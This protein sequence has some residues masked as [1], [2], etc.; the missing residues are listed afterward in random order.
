MN[1]KIGG[2]VNVKNVKDKKV[3]CLTEDQLR[4]IYK[5]VE[6][7]SIVNVDTIRQEI[8]DDK[9]T[10][11]K[12]DKVNPYQKIVVNNIDKD[13][14]PTLQMEDWSVLGNAVNYVQYGRNPNIFHE[15]N[16]KALDQKKHRL[17]YDKLKD[18]KRQT[19]DIDFGDSPD[20]LRSAY[21][22]M[23]EGVQS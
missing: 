11:D 8:E 15:L 18:D 12:E 1:M 5:K 20:K 3:K 19:L 13:N 17:M 6:S 14:I 23:Y 21:L 2:P 4:H 10:K 16:V 9:L 22:D 7:E